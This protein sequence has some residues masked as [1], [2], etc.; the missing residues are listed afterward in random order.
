[1]KIRIKVGSEDKFLFWRNNRALH[2]FLL[3]LKIENDFELLQGVTHNPNQM[4]Q[5]VGD[6]AFAWYKTTFPE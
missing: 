4:Y 2:K 1:M 3:Q 6:R 5:V